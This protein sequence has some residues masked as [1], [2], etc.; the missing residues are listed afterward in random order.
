MPPAGF[1][2]TIPANGRQQMNALY[3]VVFEIGS[4]KAR[5]GAFHS[6][7]LSMISHPLQGKNPYNVGVECLKWRHSFSGIL[8]I[9]DQ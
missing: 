9:L 3:H 2:P 6:C 1:E 4:F 7:V 5:K 8:H